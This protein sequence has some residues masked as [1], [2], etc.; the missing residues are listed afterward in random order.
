VSNA[1]FLDYYD[2]GKLTIPG[3]LSTQV[4]YGPHR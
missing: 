2:H 3:L 1:L 4:G